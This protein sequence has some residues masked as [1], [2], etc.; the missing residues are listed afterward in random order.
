[1]LLTYDL[2]SSIN[3]DSKCPWL[4]YSTSVV[5]ILVQEKKE[6]ERG[7][8]RLFEGRRLFEIFAERRGAYLRIH[9]IHLEHA[10]IRIKVIF[11]VVE[12]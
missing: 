6:K 2:Y 12:S 5:L 8:V 10:R 3:F 9:G 1:M 7:G 4:A 11:L